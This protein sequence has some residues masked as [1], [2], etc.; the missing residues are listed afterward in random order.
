M[1]R[2]DIPRSTAFRRVSFS[3]ATLVVAIA[4]IVLAMSDAHAAFPADVFADYS[5]C[6]VGCDNTQESCSAG[7]CILGGRLCSA[8]CLNNCQSA[9]SLCQTNCSTQ[10]FG[11]FDDG[12]FFPQATLRRN[13]RDVR[14]GG[15]F[16][17]PAGGV[18]DLAVTLTQQREGAVGTGQVRVPCAPDGSFVVDVHTIGAAKFRPFSSAQACGAAHVQA[19]NVSFDAFQWCREVTIV[20]DGFELEE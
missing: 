9:E 13:Q 6:L 12:A 2:T 1:K 19:A 17:C 15:P 4:S 5:N 16:E 11:S 3:G 8:R 14:L 20:P 7:C 10:Y 18:A